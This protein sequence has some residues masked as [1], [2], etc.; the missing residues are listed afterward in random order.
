M[1]TAEGR[2]RG[3]ING[4]P[5]P[6]GDLKALG[7]LLIDIHSQHEHQSLLKTDTHR[8][9][10]DEYSGSRGLARRCNWPR[11]WRQTRQTLERLSNS[12]DE[13]RARH[14]LLSYQL[15]E[16]ENL[17]LGEHELEQLE[18]EHKNGQRRAAARRL[19]PCHGAVQRGDAGNVLSAL[20]S[21]LQ[22]LT[23]FQN[24][25]QALSEAVNLLAS[26][27]IRV[28][29][30]IGELNRF[31]DHFDADP[32]RQQ[33]LEERLDTI[34]TLARKHRVQPSELPNL[35]QQLLEELE[36]LNA[37]DEAVERLGE[38]LA[39]YAR[40]YEEKAGELSRNRQ[41]AAEQLA[42]AV[43][44]EIQRLGM[45]GGRFSVQLKPAAEGEYT[46][47]GPEQVEFWSAPTLA[48]HCARWPRSR[49]AASCH[50]SAAI[51]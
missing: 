2:S 6:Q 3:Y 46:P 32:E 24:Q 1:I 4:T 39:A 10:L 42:S 37:D 31:V 13:Q 29:E 40:H 16:L 19:P 28:E 21:S 43:E 49:R 41:A 33:M 48:S 9:L 11:S 18:Q 22:R 50:G 47:Y 30:A 25:P 38:E 17:A 44:A 12:S 35:H 5:C 27:Q 51:R 15:E 34:Y 8:R 26:A 14:Q 45:P 36:G 20:T 23:A 7:E